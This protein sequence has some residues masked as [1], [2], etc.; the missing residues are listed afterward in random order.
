MNMNS[1]SSDRTSTATFEPGARIPTIDATKLEVLGRV[2]RGPQYGRLG[3]REFTLLREQSE[4]AIG[5]APRPGVTLLDR[6]ITERRDGRS[7]RRRQVI[8]AREVAAGTFRSLQVAHERREAEREAKRAGPTTPRFVDML[9]TLP[10]LQRRQPN[11][12]T[13]SPTL[14]GAEAIGG[15]GIGPEAREDLGLRPGRTAAIVVPEAPPARG[16]DGAWHYLTAGRGI[17]FGLSVSGRLALWSSHIAYPDREVIETLGE[18]VIVGL[19]NAKPARCDLPHDGEPPVA[20]TVAWPNRLPMCEP[21][22]LGEYRT[23][24]A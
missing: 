4:W 17:V 21:H 20:F 18:D 6:I 5:D 22:L 23:M 12:I 3:D 11:I 1:A 7:F 2:G 14:P 9:E 16:I 8:E 19:L 15:V 24:A 13:L 10:A